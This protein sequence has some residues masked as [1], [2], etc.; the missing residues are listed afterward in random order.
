MFE[1]V[2]LFQRIGR[3]CRRIRAGPRGGWRS[4]AAS[5]QRLRLSLVIQRQQSRITIEFIKLQLMLLGQVPD[6][7]LILAIEQI[8]PSGLGPRRKRL[9][10]L[11]Y[12]GRSCRI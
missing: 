3:I 7:L 10:A 11:A 5:R 6:Q 1:R 2:D 8:S 9:E 4:F 12:L